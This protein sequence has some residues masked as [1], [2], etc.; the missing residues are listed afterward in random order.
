ML[1][2]LFFYSINRTSFTFYNSFIREINISCNSLPVILH[3]HW[4]EACIESISLQALQVANHYAF[5]LWSFGI[6]NMIY[7]VL[8]NNDQDQHQMI[9]I[10][11]FENVEPHQQ[12]TMQASSI[13]NSWMT[14]FFP[15]FHF[16]RFYLHVQTLRVFL[17]A[18]LEPENHCR[19]NYY[20]HC[21]NLSKES[22]L[23]NLI[24]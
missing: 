13:T 12:A 4:Y 3:L 2:S 10:S 20:F 21:F 6:M 19:I 14:F 15:I 9:L 23:K 8:V 1:S 5:P 16:H 24:S 17:A 18:L 22:S 11:Y 7:V